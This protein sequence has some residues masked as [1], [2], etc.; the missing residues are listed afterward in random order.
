MEVYSLLHLEALQYQC[1]FFR[2]TR[3]GEQSAWRSHT[4]FLYSSS[5][6]ILVTLSQSQLARAGHMDTPVQEDW[7]LRKSTCMFGKQYMGTWIFCHIQLNQT[8]S[9]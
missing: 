2:V 8:S 9:R 3:A 1:V 5:K 7:A 6:E 4:Y